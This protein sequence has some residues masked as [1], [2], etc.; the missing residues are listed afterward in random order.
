MSPPATPHPPLLLS[1]AKCRSTPSHRRPFP[2]RASHASCHLAGQFCGAVSA[3]QLFA[4]AEDVVRTGGTARAVRHRSLPRAV[5]PP[6]AATKTCL[7][8][9]NDLAKM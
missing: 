6:F 1:R 4:F 5:H 3:D 2:C 8:R 9:S 7:G